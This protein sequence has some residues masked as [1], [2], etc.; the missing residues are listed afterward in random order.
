MPGY[1]DFMRRYKESCDIYFVYIL[2]AHFVEKDENGVIIEGWPIGRQ[3]N[4]PQ[5]RTMEERRE[6]AA[7]LSFELGT[8]AKHTLIDLYSNPFQ[9]TYHVWPDGALMFIDQVL[10]YQSR[11]NDNGTR[12]GIWTEEIEQL[13]VEK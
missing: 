2:E 9:N 6:M 4:I 5:H 13:L 12:P 8:P 7:R 1:L 3:Y 11:I 10:V